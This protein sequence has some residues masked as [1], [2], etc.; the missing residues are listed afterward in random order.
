MRGSIKRYQPIPK[1]NR[2]RMNPE[3]N[4]QAAVGVKVSLPRV[5]IIDD[6]FGRVHREARN[7]ERASLCGQF[8]LEDVTGDEPYSNGTQKIKSPVAQAVFYRGQTPA[9][10]G[11]GDT[12][13]N[14]LEGTLAFVKQHW[15]PV[16]NVTPLSMV[17]L[18]LCFYTGTVNAISEAKR[19]KGMPKGREGDD[20]PDRYFG[21][22]VLEALQSR[23]T[24]L[25]VV[26]LSSMPRE[27]VSQRF[28]RLGAMAFLPRSGTN[29]PVLLQEY[30]NRHGLISDPGETVI[31]RS[32]AMLL[33]LR[34]ARRAA[35]SRKNIL[36]R[37]E[38]GT[39]K[40]LLARYLH[41]Q[42][43]DVGKEPL[44]I[45][46]S[47]GLS[48]DLY[49]SEMFGH[50]KGAFT[51][52]VEDRTGRIFLANNNDLFL[53]EIGN[54]P[55]KVQEGMLRAIEQKVISPLG[56]NKE[57]PVDVRFLSATNM[58]IEEKD[59]I[60]HKF[61]KDLYYRIQEGGVIFLPPLRDR[62]EDIHLLVEKFL[63][64]AEAVTPGAMR[65]D[66]DPQAMEALLIN[67]WPG[68][69]R[70]LR[71]SIFKAVNDNWDVEYLAPCH[72]QLSGGRPSGFRN[73][74]DNA[75]SQEVAFPNCMSEQLT[76]TSI[77]LDQLLKDLAALDFSPSLEHRSEWTGKLP[78]LQ[79]AFARATAKLLG[80]AIAATRKPRA[81][82]SKGEIQYTPAVKMAMG[83]YTLV[84]TEAADIIKRIIK[85]MLSLDPDIQQQLFSDQALKE[86]Y[87][88]VCK[89]RRTKPKKAKKR[90][91][92]RDQ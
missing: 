5:L 10:A 16:D 63:R 91:T 29:S 9:A 76:V 30:L 25:P 42:K 47:G 70:E 43:P 13:E 18:D 65:R 51:G 32:K 31:G 62:K 66:I 79:T 36:L 19:G 41:D 27:E 23:F 55:M 11:L 8:L 17:L 50:V 53:D 24:D 57:C 82:N 26:I 87:D 7:E 33:A 40:E 90:L 77:N 34:A 39:G 3:M 54:M 52:A 59:F 72:L 60:D 75:E 81:G 73:E 15:Q 21:L 44:I 45:V 56:S 83:D 84:P 68:N 12:V 64:D 38:T 86:V 6:L 80:A 37:G 46:N 1:S 71:N 69:V 2:G 49:A 89:T 28:T 58:N 92:Q 88:R 4:I 74:K 48:P 67:D 85:P 22:R 20:Q 78:A 14:D 35:T 61:R